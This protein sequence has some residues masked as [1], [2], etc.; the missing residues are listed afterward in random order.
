MFKQFYYLYIIDVIESFEYD[1]IYVIGGI[2]DRSVRKS[3]YYYYYKY[4]L[5]NL[6]NFFYFLILVLISSLYL[7]IL[8]HLI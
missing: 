7:L 6:Q 8:E 4:I 2:V 1:S 3:R 5:I